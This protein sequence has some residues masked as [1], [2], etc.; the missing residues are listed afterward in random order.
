MKMTKQTYLIRCAQNKTK[1]TLDV[2]P[3]NVKIH[4]MLT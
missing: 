3:M 1:S 2:M 4:A